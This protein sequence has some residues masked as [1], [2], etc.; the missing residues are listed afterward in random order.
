MCILVEFIKRRFIKGSI[1]YSFFKESVSFQLRNTPF[2][3]HGCASGLDR[4]DY[5]FIERMVHVD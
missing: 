4:F 3:M 2:K 5:I 1:L